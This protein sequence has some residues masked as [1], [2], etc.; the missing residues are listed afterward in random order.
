MIDLPSQSCCSV[1]RVY[2]HENI[3]DEFVEAAVAFAASLKVGDPS[4][5]KT[6]MGPL[7]LPNQ[8]KFLADQV[9]ING[10]SRVVRVLPHGE[11]RDVIERM[12]VQLTEG[13]AYVCGWLV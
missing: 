13:V 8:P 10:E 3:Y 2:V 11:R 6:Y 12:V 4:D 5:P 1:E 9:A 7:A